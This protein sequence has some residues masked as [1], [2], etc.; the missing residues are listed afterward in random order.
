MK[1]I[2]KKTAA[3]I[4]VA[5]SLL[6]GI[7]ASAAR[8][9]PKLEGRVTDE[10]GAPVEYATIVLLSSD[11]EQVAGTTSD[12]E[13]CFSLSARA[14]S[15][16][17]KI[18]YLGYEDVTLDVDLASPVKLPDIAL[19]PVST[20]VEAVR[21]TGQAIVREADRFVV[22]VANTPAAI[23][24]DA[25]EMLKTS[26]GIWV[27]GN[28]ITINGRSGT[29][30]MINDRMLRQT[31]EDLENYLR[32]IKAED[33]LKIEIIPQ[34]GA[35][36]D[37]DATGG[38]I[39]ITLSK[40]RNDGI[41]GNVNLSGTTGRFGVRSIVPGIGL[42]YQSGKLSLYG[43]GGYGR[44]KNYG[45]LSE[46]TV[47][48]SDD[49][50]QYVSDSEMRHNGTTYNAR[51]GVVYDFDQRNSLGAEFGYYYRGGTGTTD[52]TSRMTASSAVE[53]I[54]SLYLTDRNMDYYNATVNYIRKF[55]DK[56][57]VFKLIGD[58]AGSKGS[59]INVNKDVF[60]SGAFPVADI[61]KD[62]SDSDFGI[63]S[64]NA[65]FDIVRSPTTTIK[66]GAKYTY[67]S[68]NSVIDISTG[69]DEG[70]LVKDDM[71]SSR[72][73]YTEN[74][75]ALYF[76][77]NTRLGK[78]G[79]S[80]GLRGEYT[81][82]IPKFSRDGGSEGKE[83]GYFDL[84]PN[85]NV[86]VPL[87][88][89]YSNMLVLSY[90]RNISRPHFSYLS[91]FRNQVSTYS[92]IAGNPDLKPTYAN[93]ISLTGV[94][95]YKYSLTL[96]AMISQNQ[97]MQ[98][99]NEEGEYLVYRFENIP[100]TTQYFASLNA[101]VTITDWWTANIN[102]TALEMTQKLTEN[103]S[104]QRRFTV[105]TNVSTTLSIP[106]WF[107]LE[108]NHNYMSKIMN[109]NMEVEPMHFLTATV[110]KRFADNKFT[111]SLSVSNIL[112]MEQKVRSYGP[113]FEKWAYV[114]NGDHLTFRLSL[115]YNF[116]AGVKVKAKK[117]ER[118]AEDDI[119]RLGAS[120]NQ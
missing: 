42:N 58:Y 18:F 112:Y 97:I 7:N 29:R 31:G 115:R 87:N 80:A 67:N 11:M 22:T 10:N 102:V 47:N 37:A 49:P 119:K 65:N 16:T 38:I 83:K 41:E 14:G 40:Q 88:P 105:V 98:K 21:V 59:D 52:G 90:S 55:G 24:K 117:V 71:Q 82:I 75:G 77:Y 30:V 120:G 45:S 9:N 69:S 46:E 6:F 107:D 96:G 70:S 109:A 57:S 68:I 28:D 101:P 4:F 19:V 106:K 23:G 89:T 118:G 91:P 85:L 113:E 72:T 61:L 62:V 5:L 103:A 36:Y 64:L 74:I 39:K 73:D 84:F 79:L 35:D 66:T 104:T 94:F 13:G 108:L 99:V 92:Y 3:C 56:G 8:Q 34:A 48:W 2:M 44:S 63:Y 1:Y 110:K 51:L 116:N 114:Y 32:S 12:G 81:Y 93:N 20:Q 25:F 17:A 15:Y 54:E 86:S 76:I 100:S 60:V 33:I 53:D 43:N 26:P 78:V 95:A 27:N 50:W 111:A